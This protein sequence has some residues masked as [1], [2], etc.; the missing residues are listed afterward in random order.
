MDESTHYVNVTGINKVR[1][2][3]VEMTEIAK[4]KLNIFSLSKYE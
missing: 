4:I 2:V 1:N 3:T